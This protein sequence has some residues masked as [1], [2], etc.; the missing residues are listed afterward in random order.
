MNIAAKQF[1]LENARD[2][3]EAA[4]QAY[5]TAGDVIV[6]TATDT[7]VLV[8]EKA[9]HIIVAFRG[10][11]SIRDWIIDAEF[12]RVVLVEEP[13]GDVCEVHSGFLAAYESVIELLAAHLKKIVVGDRPV[14]VTGHSLGGALAIL[15]ALELNRQKFTV[16]QVY[17]FGQP[18]VGN[19][20]FKRLY[21]W[22]LGT[23]TFRVVYQEDIVPR[24]PHLPSW[25]D[26][27]RH[28]GTEIFL[29]SLPGGLIVNPPLSRLLLSDAWGIYRAFCISK[30]AGALNPIN[31]HYMT[32]YTIALDAIVDFVNPQKKAGE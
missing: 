31:D 6:A 11:S 5:G 22:S 13:N 12:F 3:A 23:S 14:F 19:A 30:F 16:A 9:D 28:V 10:T 20:A 21:E 1:D 2:C 8:I 15:A 26:L 27:Y 24:L 17:T 7:Q 32:N 4:Y 29:S 25:R 18:R